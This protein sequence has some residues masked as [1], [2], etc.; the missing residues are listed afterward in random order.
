MGRQI[1]KTHAVVLRARR[2][3]ET[4]KLVTFYSHEFGKIKVVAKGARRPKSKFGAALEIMTEVSAV[5]YLRDDRD[6][7]TLS[8]CDVVTAYPGLLSDFRR[9]SFGSAACE[10]VDRLTI[11]HEPNERLFTC[12]TGFLFALEEVSEE[13]T[14][15]L[16]WYF[17]LRVAEALGYRPEL[18]ACVVC[19]GDLGDCESP[20]F[21]AALGGGL[22]GA[23]HREEVGSADV[24]YWVREGTASG[25]PSR[26]PTRYDRPGGHC[27]ARDSL[28]FLAHLQSIRAYRKDAIPP[29][30]VRSAEIRAMLSDF[31]EYHGG[32]NGRL[33]ALQFLDTAAN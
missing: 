9:M 23:C 13:Q 25:Y 6:L 29:A 3:G 16:F 18:R 7:Q 31:L 24:G 5:C 14:E 22:C 30:P 17:Q 4:S 1:V 21:S 15:S 11:E 26:G 8:D 10:S 20:Y 33:K 27:V 28:G 12:L 2:M 32:C 19:G